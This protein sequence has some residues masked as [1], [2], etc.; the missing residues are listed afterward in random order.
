MDPSR[1]IPILRAHTGIKRLHV[2]D[3][4]V[5]TVLSALALVTGEKTCE[6]LPA[7][8]DLHVHGTMTTPLVT[9][10][11]T[12]EIF[13]VPRGLHFPGRPGSSAST[14]A[15]FEPFITSRKLN[16][17][18]VSVHYEGLETGMTPDCS[19]E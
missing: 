12:P 6:I 9:G 15:F 4:L 5:W 19:S 14:F 17:L 8:R 1:W 16:G 2:V 7:L 11:T 18:P 10:E 13:P 3:T